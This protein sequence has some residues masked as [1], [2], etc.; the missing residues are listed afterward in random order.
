MVP[1]YNIVPRNVRPV[2][3]GAPIAIAAGVVGVT[4]GS[5]EVPNSNDVLP[6]I[7]KDGRTEYSARYVQNVGANPCFYSFGQDCNA[8]AYHGVLAAGQ[9]LACSDCGARVNVYSA[10]G[11]TIVTTVF[12]RFDQAQHGNVLPSIIP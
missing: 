12:R 2:P 3:A 1:V 9:Q 6:D 10:L 5:G 4:D 7:S 8:A 11:T